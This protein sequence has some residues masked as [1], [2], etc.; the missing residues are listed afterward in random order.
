MEIATSDS[1]EE[2]KKDFEIL[3]TFVLSKSSEKNEKYTNLIKENLLKL[4]ENDIQE[5]WEIIGFD[6]PELID[7]FDH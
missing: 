7:L 3:K 2:I 4:K 5:N 1:E 6:Y